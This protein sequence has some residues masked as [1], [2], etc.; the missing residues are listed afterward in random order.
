MS[1]KYTALVFAQGKDFPEFEQALND[2][3]EQAL[4]E[5]LLDFAPDMDTWG[6]LD[7]W[8]Y[9]PWGQ[10]DRIFDRFYAQ[11]NFVVSYNLKYGYAG[12][13]LVTE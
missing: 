13:S 10:S 6:Y 7:K 11:K 1:K 4:F 3:G 5:K 9:T 12:L 2:G 8:D